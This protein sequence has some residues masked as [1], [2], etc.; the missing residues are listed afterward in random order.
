MY[1]RL[2]NISTADTAEMCKELRKHGLWSSVENDCAHRPISSCPRLL[3]LYHGTA[4]GLGTFCINH[5]QFAWTYNVY[6][7]PNTVLAM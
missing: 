7:M 4:L 5:S 6:Y 2:Y 3:T 1:N